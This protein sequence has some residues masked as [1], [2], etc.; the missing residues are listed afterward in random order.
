MMTPSKKLVTMTAGITL[1]ATLLLALAPNLTIVAFTVIGLFACIVIIDLIVSWERITTLEFSSKKVVR[2]T[3]DKQMELLIEV[4]NTAQ[5]HHN[6]RL[7]LHMPTALESNEPVVDVEVMPDQEK[8]PAIWPIVPRARGSYSFNDLHVERPTKWGFWHLR[9]R[10]PI[11]LE[12]R[13]FPNLVRESRNAAAL[14]LNHSGVGMHKL[15]LL[16]KGREFEKLRE[17]L[18][19]DSYEDIHWKAAAKRGKPITKVYQ[20]ERT[21]EVYVIIDS[22]RLS[23]RPGHPNDPKNND[24]QLERFLS[25]ALILGLAAEKQGDKFGILT[26]SNRIDNF[27]RAQN[28]RSHYGACR[29]A[30]YALEPNH[31]SPDFDELFRFIRVRLTRRALL[32][33]LTNLDDPIIAENFERNVSLIS[34]QHLVIA[35][36]L[37]PPD[38]KPIFSDPNVDSLKEVYSSLGAHY[39]WV[40]LQELERNLKRQGITFHLSESPHLCTDVINHYMKVKQR[41]V[42]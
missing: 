28:G 25:T 35:N 10:H 19:G 11:N 31:V 24:H 1:P 38:C 39:R 3:R 16:G 34:R 26:F 12:L 5:G 14:F 27:L 7:G 13:V 18:P 40:E 23:N 2:A 22:S 4:I 42:L 15:R 37:M 29:D 33:F 20:T 41:Q 17:Y 32:I 30:I 8:T 36:Q 6:L 9:S 21:Q